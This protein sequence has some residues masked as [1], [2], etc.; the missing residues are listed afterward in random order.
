MEQYSL[1]ENLAKQAI[2]SA[3]NELY[4]KHLIGQFDDGDPNNPRY[5]DGYNY[6]TGQYNLFG[7]KQNE[8]M[9]KQYK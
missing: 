2:L 7:Y 3:D 8:L 1:P 4:S 5:N 6:A 9:D